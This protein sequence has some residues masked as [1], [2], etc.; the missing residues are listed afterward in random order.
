MSNMAGDSARADTEI[1]S[2]LTH[3][4]PLWWVMRMFAITRVHFTGASRFAKPSIVG[5]IPT[6]ASLPPVVRLR[7]VG[8][9]RFAFC[10]VINHWGIPT[11]SLR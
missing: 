7:R 11:S 4:Q 10:D 6:S 5:S 1:F 8:N 9:M 3:S 2:S